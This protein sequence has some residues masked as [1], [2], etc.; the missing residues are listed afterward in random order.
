MDKRRDKRRHRRRRGGGEEPEM[1]PKKVV[2]E[3][4]S[5]TKAEVLNSAPLFST[6]IPPPST[7]ISH[8][9]GRLK[10]KEG[11]EENPETLPEELKIADEQV[12]LFSGEGSAP[13]EELHKKFPDG[14][15]GSGS[16][17]SSVQRMT[18]LSRSFSDYFF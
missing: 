7:L 8:T 17:S 13:Q 3:M 15:E 11:L 9:L 16:E 2:E 10:E 18:S 6:L 1:A 4:P 14:P 5:E 12:E